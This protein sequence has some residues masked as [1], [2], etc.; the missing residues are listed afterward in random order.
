MVVISSTRHEMNLTT[1]YEMKLSGSNLLFGSYRKHSFVEYG[2]RMA[3]CRPQ[4]LSTENFCGG[5]DMIRK[6]H[7]EEATL[8]LYNLTLPPAFDLT[9]F[10]TIFCKRYFHFLSF[11]WLKLLAFLGERI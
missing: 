5:A 10:C 6:R 4:L 11:S 9:I 3:V 7:Q 8:A 2:K 1:R